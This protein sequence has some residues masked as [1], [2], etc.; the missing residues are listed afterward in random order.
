[1][2]FIK[3]NLKEDNP[4]YKWRGY[5]CEVTRVV[6]GERGISQFD[7]NVL[8][9]DLEGNISKAGRLDQGMIMKSD[10]FTIKNKTAL[11]LH[12]HLVVRLL[13]MTKL[14]KDKCRLCNA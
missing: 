1:M 10:T 12:K 2:R 8:A 4:W 3:T 13:Q 7:I 14:Y 11:E 5:P 9:M 6:H